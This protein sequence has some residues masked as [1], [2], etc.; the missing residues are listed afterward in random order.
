MVMKTSGK[1]YLGVGCVSMSILMTILITPI[2]Q[3][4][5][6][7]DWEGINQMKLCNLIFFTLVGVCV[8]GMIYGIVTTE[9]SP[10]HASVEKNE[11]IHPIK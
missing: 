4:N 8:G 9:K 1:D 7:Y 10:Q 3:R 5:A 6:N 2:Y 11:Q